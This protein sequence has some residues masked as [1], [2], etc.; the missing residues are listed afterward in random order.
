M[1]IILWHPR[2]GEVRPTK[3]QNEQNINPTSVQMKPTITSKS[4]QND[5][6]I[7]GK[8]CTGIQ[9]GFKINLGETWGLVGFLLRAA[10]VSLGCQDGGQNLFKKRSEVD[11]KINNFIFLALLLLSLRSRLWYIS[12]RFLGVKLRAMKTKVVS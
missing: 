12:F 3:Q 7:N 11:Q 6:K 9:I 5:F 8:G 10:P 1:A 4:T 2:S